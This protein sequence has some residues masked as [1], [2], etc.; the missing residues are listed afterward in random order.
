MAVLVNRLTN[1]IDGELRL[2]KKTKND[3]I[4][5]HNKILHFMNAALLKSSL[6]TINRNMKKTRSFH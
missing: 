1:V 4:D 3:E 5:I 6:N 2:F